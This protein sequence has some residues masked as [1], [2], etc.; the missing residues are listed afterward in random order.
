MVGRHVSAAPG[1]TYA[2]EGLEP[3]GHPLLSRQ[4]WGAISTP[5]RRRQKACEWK[6]LQGIGRSESA[7]FSE[8]LDFR[9]AL[10]RKHAVETNPHPDPLPFRK[11]EGNL[12]WHR[13]RVPNTDP[14][15]ERSISPLP[16]R[17]GERI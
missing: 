10:R 17:S 5:E 3:G 6:A 13:V 16:A 8:R 1:E 11:G 9:A 2:P 12:R 4:R 14:R 7:A 15:R